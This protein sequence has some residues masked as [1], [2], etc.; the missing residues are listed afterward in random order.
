MK[1]NKHVLFVA[2]LGAPILGMAQNNE[3]LIDNG[4]FEATTGKIKKLGQ[5]D[6]ATGWVSPTGA[7][8]DVFL[9]GSKLP[10][11]GAPNNIYGK[12]APK[13]GENYA[14][15]VAFS[16]GDKMPRTYLMAKLKT[17]LKKD[18]KYCISFN[19]SLAEWS[20]YSSNQIGINVSKKAFG[21]DEK[22]AIIDE[23]QI[24]HPNNK[25]FN[26]MYNWDKVCGTFTADGGEKY[27]TIGNFTNNESTKSERN[28]KPEDLKGTQI[29]AA[30]YYIDDVSVKIIS[31]KEPCDCPT[32]EEDNS[33]S[34]TIY[35]RAIVLNDKMTPKE[36]I[37]AQ[38]VYFAFGKDKLTQQAIAALDLV[39]TEMKA[40]PEIMLDLTGHSDTGEEELAE[41]KAYYA[42]MDKKRLVVVTKY[43]TDKGIATNRIKSTPK[44]SGESNPE[45]VEADD[46]DLKFA[47]NRRVTLMVN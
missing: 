27:I 32:D 19:L 30:Y 17:P 31:D 36:K 25:I 34:S 20:K 33:V 5:I 47:K 21:T 28:K 4:G 13:E 42:G 29:I 18:V 45:I 22:T 23:T 41:K 8:A 43:L 16:F 38:G 14:G 44:G 35:Q 7:R 9:S 39:A 46:D 24:I 1:I 26:A 37:E 3:N 40:H 10:E 6:L 12:E 11:I 15:I 2:L